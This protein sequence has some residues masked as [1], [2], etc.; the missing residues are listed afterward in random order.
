MSSVLR[1]DST[2][3]W[4]QALPPWLLLV[5]VVLV[6]YRDT[7]VAMVEIW[8]RSDTFAHAF[9]VPPIAAW[10]IWRQREALAALSPRPAAWVL[11]LLAGVGIVWLLGALGAGNSVTQLAFT[12]L[13]VLTVPAVIGMEAAR[14]MLFPL[15]FLFFAVPIGEFV[16][17]QLMIWTADFTA[18]ALRF[19][20]IP[21]YR[22]GLQLVI[23]SGTWHIVEACSGVRY[24]IASTMVGTLFAYLTFKSLR[25]RLIFVGISILVPIVAN[26][27]RAYFIVLLGHVSNNQLAVGADHLI[28][29]WVFFGVVIMLMFM[30]GTRFAAPLGAAMTPPSSTAPRPKTAAVRPWH[31]GAGWAVACAGAVLA[32]APQVALWR[33]DAVNGDRQVMLTAPPALADGWHLSTAPMT[34]WK[35]GFE[36]PSAEITGAYEAG[37]APVGL[38]IAYYRQQDFKRKLV[39]SDNVLVRSDDPV[40]AQVSA[41]SKALMLGGTP[42]TMGT[43]EL[44]AKADSA[45]SGQAPLLVWQ[46]YWVN[47]RLTTS[48]AAAR[49]YG[50]LGRL[51]GQ[52]DDSAVIMFYTREAPGAAARDTLGSFVQTNLAAIGARLTAVRDGE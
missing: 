7:A 51:R 13:L 25:G 9:V 30:I 48:D 24:L 20:G 19:S 14:V 38:Y 5:A 2:A 37:G 46:T 15:C 50:V 21:V 43:A 34:D 3:P 12:A 40:W 35:P 16:V 41:G 6:L 42:V 45:D 8:S 28:Y 1:S 10:L 29:G 47:G 49:A 44:R 18:L 11:S 52:G 32:L 39:S 33:V 36:N 26:W 17:P 4:R 22:E 27:V 31:A 23:P